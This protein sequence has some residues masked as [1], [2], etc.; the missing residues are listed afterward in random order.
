MTNPLPSRPVAGSGASARWTAAHGGAL[1]RVD[2]VDQVR[3]L[4]KPGK[5]TK[6]HGTSPV[7]MGKST[8]NGKKKM[9]NRHAHWVNQLQ[10]SKKTM[11]HPQVE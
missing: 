11:E 7:S 8:T 3:K 2:T 6:N 4:T 10:I 5:P 9:K 1:Q